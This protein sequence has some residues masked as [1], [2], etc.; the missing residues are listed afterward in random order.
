MK[1]KTIYHIRVTMRCGS[2]FFKYNYGIFPKKIQY[3]RI[4][5]NVIEVTVAGDKGEGFSYRQVKQSTK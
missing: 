3:K 1:L 2:F 5:E 4:S